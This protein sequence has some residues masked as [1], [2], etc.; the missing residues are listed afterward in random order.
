M[1]LGLTGHLAY[2]QLPLSWEMNGTWGIIAEVVFWHP[3]TYA[4]RRDSGVR[5]RHLPTHI[6]PTKKIKDIG[7]TLWFWGLFP[8]RQLEWNRWLVTRNPP[9]TS[10]CK[11]PSG[12]SCC[13]QSG[14]PWGSTSVLNANL[15]DICEPIWEAMT[16][17]TFGDHKSP[18]I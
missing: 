17:T 11:S 7:Q 9:L 14:T 13:W 8:G 6:H 15:A 4:Q 10:H 1:Y 12:A 5:V 3:Q 2:K 16:E 18:Q